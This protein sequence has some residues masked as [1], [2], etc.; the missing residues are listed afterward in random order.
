MRSN[1]RNSKA[2]RLLQ[3]SRILNFARL[4]N[5]LVDLFGLE[6]GFEKVGKREGQEVELQIPSL[7]GFLSFTLVSQKADFECRAE[8]AQNPKATIILN[9]E[10]DNVIK[11]L[12]NIIRSKPNIFGLMRL[13]PKFL[14]GKI[15]VK[16]SLFATLALVRCIMIGKN[17]I[18]KK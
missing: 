14:T 13:V 18:Y 10:K 15:K 17:E 16:G 6:E 8:R 11:V 5:M 12:S 3:Q 9:V 2:L 7:N 1:D 4:A